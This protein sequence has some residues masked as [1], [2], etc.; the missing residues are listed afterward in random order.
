MLEHVLNVVHTYFTTIFIIFK[1]ELPI[2]FEIG[3]RN[4]F[5]PLGSFP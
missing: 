5:K 4:L 1:F 3:P 2:S